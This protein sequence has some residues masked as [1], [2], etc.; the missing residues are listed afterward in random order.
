MIDVRRLFPVI[1]VLAQE[2]MAVL[3]LSVWTGV[4]V[5]R[6]DALGQSVVAGIGEVAAGQRFARW[7]VGVRDGVVC[8]DPHS[9][10]VGHRRHAGL[11]ALLLS[12][13]HDEE[14]EEEEAEQDQ[15][16]DPRDG[17]DLVRVHL[18][19]RA[20]QTVETAHHHHT[21][22]VTTSPLPAWATV[23]RPS[24]VITCGVILT[25][26]HLAAAVTIRARGT[27]LFAEAAHETC[28]AGAQSGDVVTVASVP[29]LAHLGAVF[30]KEAQRATLSAVEAGPSWGALAFA[31]VGAAVGPVVT[32][33]CMDA[34]RSPQSRRT[35]LGAVAADPPWVT[36]TGAVDGVT[37]AVVGAAAAPGT[38]LAKASTRADLVAQ[39]PP[40]A[41]EAIA[42]SCDVVARPVTVDTLRTRLAAAVAEVARRANSL[43]GGAPVSWGALA[44]AFVWRAG[45]S[46]LA[47]AGERAVG[48]PA[49]LCTNTVTVNASPASEAVAVTS[50]VVTS[51][52]VAAVTAL[53]AF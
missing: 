51:I 18:Y 32:I 25:V 33:A 16:D 36:L 40:E 52:S 6:A 13:V 4:E 19:G 31:I 49:A 29:A 14:E 39:R 26:A 48:T 38:V 7:R 41:R 30:P 21:S 35:R 24:H 42:L 50:G 11:F 20:G 53:S 27:L 23:A 3:C 15:H 22:L 9:R 12:P 1:E 5:R 34:V 43:A 10:G 37:C 28:A 47:V 17:S 46:V 2:Q 45:S 8:R 44:G